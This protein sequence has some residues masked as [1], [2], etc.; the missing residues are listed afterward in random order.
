GGVDQPMTRVERD[1]EQRAGLPFK[2]VAPG[3]TLLPHFGR[4]AAFDHQHDL[5]VE[6]PLLVERARGRDL[7]HV[8]APKAFG[9]IELDVAAAAAEPPPRRHRQGLPAAPPDAPEDRP[10]PPPHQP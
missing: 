5:L 6:M 4:A 9:A 10:A 3:L 8:A 1:R 2:S 7:D